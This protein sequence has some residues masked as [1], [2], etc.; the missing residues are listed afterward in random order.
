MTR[1]SSASGPQKSVSW[2]S[3]FDGGIP[4]VLELME[5]VMMTL[6]PKVSAPC[7][8]IHSF[9]PFNGTPAFYRGG[10]L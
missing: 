10:G 1:N 7:G 3:E 5:L 4:Q 6:S 8:H 2:F 9:Y